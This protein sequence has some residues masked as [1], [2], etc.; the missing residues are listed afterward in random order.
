VFS[1]QFSVFSREKTAGA[2]GRLLNVRVGRWRTS[3]P[4]ESPDVQEARFIQMERRKFKGGTGAVRR[5]TPTVG[6][7]NESREGGRILERK[8]DLRPE[9]R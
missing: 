6:K 8:D 3:C 9:G 7:N 5:E 1:V 2:A 4:G